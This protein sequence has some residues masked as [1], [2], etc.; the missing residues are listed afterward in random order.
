[1]KTPATKI[2]SLLLGAES[3]IVIQSMT[4]T[5]TADA[6]A[7]ASQCIELAVAGAEMVRVTVNTDRAAQAVPEIR[8]IL[9]KSGYEHLPLIGD[10]HYNGHS[11]LKAHPSCARALDKYRI[12]PGNVGF[13]DKHQYNFA[14]IIEIALEHSKPVRI[15]VNWGSLDQELFTEMMDQNAKRK[16]PKSDRD[17]IVDAMVES[18]LRSA[19]MAEKLGMKHQNIVLSVKMSQ[20]EDMVKAY[21]LLAKRAKGRYPLHLGL[22]EAGSGLQGIVSSTAALAILLNQGIGDTIRISLTPDSENPR[23]REV[24]VAKQLLQSLGLR[25]FRP[26]VTSCPG[27]GR[28]SS[29]FFQ[30]LAKE[31]N[32]HIDKNLSDW[33]EK[34]PGVETLKIAVMGCVVN[35]PGEAAHADVAISL[36]GKMEKKV[37]P[38]YIDGKYDQS[39]QGDQITAQFIEIVENY[40]KSR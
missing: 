37:A 22:T 9:D 25:Y 38:V 10:F 29:T 7:T 20:V 27:C 5:D 8:A 40:L 16:N 31:I 30:E 4:N 15:G 23:T 1:M 32:Q 14:Q 24:E 3:P 2:R 33:R 12:N 28:T 36:P 21:Q 35:G 34:Y 13:G 26:Q 39:L 6:K 18:A 19:K 11:L 17:V